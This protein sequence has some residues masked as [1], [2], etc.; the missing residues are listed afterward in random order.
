MDS[1]CSDLLDQIQAWAK[2]WHEKG[3]ISEALLE[4][5]KLDKSP[6]LELFEDTRPLVVAFFGGTGVG[7]STLLNRLA[8][9][10]VA[11][12][13]IER[14]TSRE[15]TFYLHA[16]LEPQKLPEIPAEKVKL[17]F[18]QSEK[19]KQIVWVDLPDIDSLEQEGK[20][21]TLSLLPYFDVLIYVVS[22]ERYRDELGFRVV[23]ERK[24]ESLFLFV[25]SHW[26]K[27]HKL[28]LEDFKRELKNAGFCDPIVL[29]CDNR[30]TQGAP[31]DFG[32][33][34]ELLEDFV[35]SHGIEALID[36]NI[37]KELDLIEVA[38]TRVLES[39]DGKRIDHLI[40]RW[41]TIWKDTQ[42]AI[43]PGLKGSAVILAREVGVLG[44]KKK[45]YPTSREENGPALK[46]AL[47]LDSWTETFL[48]DALDR[49][50]LE[51]ED[52]GVPT[53]PVR[54]RLAPIKSQL[55]K[56]LFDEVQLNLRRA[57]A[58]PGSWF[59]RLLVWCFRKLT[60]LLPLAVSFWVGERLLLGF[61]LKTYLGIDFAIHS[62][63]LL[64]CAFAIPKL[65]CLLF[66][67]SLEKA[68][69][70]GIQQGLA[71]GLERIALE[72]E[73]KLSEIKSEILTAQSEG[74]CLKDLVKDYRLKGT[75]KK[76]AVVSSPLLERMLAEG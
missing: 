34:V 21:L 16:S 47:A 65:F 75:E 60:F 25:M 36:R 64:G 54:K 56:R 73:L 13:G 59:R 51:A 44:T 7:K 57:L 20:E 6:H 53:D 28:Q 14:P 18:H 41:R 40:E 23:R 31:D 4:E 49:L 22:P 10:K 63:A 58:T 69:L 46:Q 68:A 32:K 2:T 26:D 38:L 5:L 12:T 66:E 70:S 43:R 67:P 52:L 55:K 72:V 30:E 33:L 24:K 3:F 17:V 9:E 62:A 11:K 61:Y 37:Q 71:S 8:G 19:F 74:R 35:R 15:V 50:T 1:N 45:G 76:Q 39:L 29:R 48:Q 42:K 27:A